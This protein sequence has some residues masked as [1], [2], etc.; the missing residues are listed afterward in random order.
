MLRFLFIRKYFNDD[1]PDID[2]FEEVKLKH[3][4]ELTHILPFR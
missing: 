2:D 1:K 3:F 4:D